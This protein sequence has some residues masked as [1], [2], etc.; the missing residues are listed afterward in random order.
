MKFIIFKLSFIDEVNSIE[1]SHAMH[2]II[3]INS[4]IILILIDAN[5]L[6]VNI[7]YGIVLKATNY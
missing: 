2:L 3:W 4:A 5:L 6:A 7:E 1:F